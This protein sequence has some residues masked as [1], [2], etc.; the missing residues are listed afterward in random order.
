[1]KKQDENSLC[2]NQA[3]TAAKRAV[4][5]TGRGL[6]LLPYTIRENLPILGSQQRLG[7]KAKVLTRWFT[8]EGSRAWYITE[9]SARRDPDG[10]AVDYLLYGLVEGQ[11]RQ[12]DYFWLSDLS[13]LRSPTG[14]SVER[15]SHWQPKMLQEIAPEMFQIDPKPRED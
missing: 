3:V 15:D 4:P 2:K 1:M 14:L 9:G 10:K 13:T 6:K 5:N 7:G 12:L 8:P 11:C